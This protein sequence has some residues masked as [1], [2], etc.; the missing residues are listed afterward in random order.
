[1][2][3]EVSDAARRDLAAAFTYLAERNLR[4]A[5]STRSAIRNAILGLRQ[6][7]NRGRLGESPGTRELIVGKT[8]YVV[9]YSV[10]AI[11]VFIARIRHTRQDPSP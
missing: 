11:T 8:P 7:P 9:V 3:V 6:F 10:S 4:A 2:K 1:M 5:Q